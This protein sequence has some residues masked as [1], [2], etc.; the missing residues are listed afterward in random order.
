MLTI[1]TSIYKS[2]KYIKKYIEHLISVGNFLQD[3]IDF[4]V[5][6]VANDLSEKEEKALATCRDKKWFKLL[7]VPRE[8]L[9]ASWNRGVETAKGDIVGFWNTDDIRYPE[10]L[11]GGVKLIE[12]GADLVYFPFIIKWYLNFFN[13][14]ILVKKKKILPDIYDRNKFT[15]GMHCGPFFL[16]SKEFYKKVGP[17]DEQFKIV[18]DFDWCVRAA[19]ISNNFVL[20]EV[21]A[22]EFR[23]DGGGLSAGGKHRFKVENSV[24]FKR[25]DIPIK[26]KGITEKE[27]EKFNFSRILHKGNFINL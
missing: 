3:K 25:H 10:A 9:Y 18:G 22:G 15:R 11:L 12:E 13:I 8:S 4:E 26:L 21:N 24:V 27:I 1:I 19:K 14:G 20:S 5:I 16:F 6:I 23:V 7:S 17:F 2:E